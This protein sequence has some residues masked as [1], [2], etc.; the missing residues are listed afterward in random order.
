MAGNGFRLLLHLG[1]NAIRLDRHFGDLLRI[2]LIRRS[3]LVHRG[4]D[5]IR[6]L[7]ELALAGIGSLDVIR[8]VHHILLGAI[9]GL[10]RLGGVCNGLGDIAIGDH[11]P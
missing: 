3:H 4:P 9:S 5:L 2:R 6:G 11:R 8:Q 1:G 10:L 7:L